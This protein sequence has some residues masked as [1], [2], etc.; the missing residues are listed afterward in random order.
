MKVAPP[1]ARG[2]GKRPTIL[3]WGTSVWLPLLPLAL[4]I[5]NILRQIKS[6]LLTAVCNNSRRPRSISNGGVAWCERCS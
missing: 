3:K 2:C 6:D 5:P 4:L 1:F